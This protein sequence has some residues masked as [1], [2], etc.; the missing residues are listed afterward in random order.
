MS[1][2][3][4]DHKHMKFVNI[5]SFITENLTAFSILQSNFKKN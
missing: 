1:D 3:S 4:F 2:D 5:L